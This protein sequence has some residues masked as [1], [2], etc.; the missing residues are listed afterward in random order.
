MPHT[1]NTAAVCM[2]IWIRDLLAGHKHGPGNRM[3][4]C[5][6]PWET[7]SLRASALQSAAVT[8]KEEA[9]GMRAATYLSGRS[10]CDRITQWQIAHHRRAAA[11]QTL[12]DRVV[13]VL[14]T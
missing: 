10:I 9:E 2:P 4:I 7:I 3:E 1:V 6:M 5:R 12:D 14:Y 11:T 8:E 13:R